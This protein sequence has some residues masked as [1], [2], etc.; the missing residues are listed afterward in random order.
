MEHNNVFTF[1]SAHYT[2]TIIL[3]Y[4]RIPNKTNYRTFIDYV[5][6]YTVVNNDDRLP[7]F[8]NNNNR[9]KDIFFC[10]FHTSSLIVENYKNPVD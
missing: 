6:K 2:K 4:T 9:I 1:F 7:T 8:Y 5:D 3:L 10:R